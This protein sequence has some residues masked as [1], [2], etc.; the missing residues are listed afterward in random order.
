MNSNL[1]GTPD[2]FKM[3]PTG[4]PND[5]SQAKVILTASKLNSVS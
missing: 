1:P 3:H 2:Q 4:I 5:N